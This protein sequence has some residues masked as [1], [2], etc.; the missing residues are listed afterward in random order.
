LQL[1]VARMP[2]ADDNSSAG[3]EMELQ[4]LYWAIHDESASYRS[5][6]PVFV[7]ESNG[8]RVPRQI[9]IVR[10]R[11]VLVLRARMWF[12]SRNDPHRYQ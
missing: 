9:L 6:R 8:I 2:H 5:V 11:T 3:R 7:N 4:C 12:F 1:D 10:F